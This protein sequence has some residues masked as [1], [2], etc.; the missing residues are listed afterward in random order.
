MHVCMY[1]FMHICM[2]VCVCIYIYLYKKSFTGT[3]T[4]K[5]IRMNK[6]NAQT[7]KNTYTWTKQMHK[8]EKIQSTHM[9]QATEK[10]ANATRY[11][12][13][14]TSCQQTKPNSTCHT[15]TRTRTRTRTHTTTHPH[16]HPHTHTQIQGKRDAR[17]ARQHWRHTISKVIY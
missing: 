2:Y 11:T 14:Y 8:Y 16:P 3:C 13:L 1:L 12:T 7:W 5:H 17:C 4:K 6:T 9:E 15:H 10:M